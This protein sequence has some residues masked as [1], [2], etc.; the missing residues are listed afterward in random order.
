VPPPI[1]QEAF[2][3]L[4]RRRPGFDTLAPWA[5]RESCRGDPLAFL[6]AG[7]AIS[8]FD[9][10]PWLGQ[11][12]V[13]TASVI[14]TE[15][16]TVPPAAQQALAAA[17][18]DAEVFPVAADH[19]ACIDDPRQFLPAFVAA[20]HHVSAAA[21][22]TGGATTGGRPHVARSAPGPARD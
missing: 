10:T 21:R 3:R 1:R 11:I 18:P 19:R 20:C 22:R 5:Q 7:A 2:R 14:T 4:V 6:Q 17:I 13:P 12:D 9:S 15:D 16:G 8:R